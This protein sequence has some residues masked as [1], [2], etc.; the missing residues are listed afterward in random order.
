MMAPAGARQE[1]RKDFRTGLLQGLTAA[2]HGG[3]KK[4]FQE[5]KGGVV[6]LGCVCT[7]EEVIF[8]SYK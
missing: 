4:P 8:F 7:K 6:S 3:K 2:I 1:P 5:D